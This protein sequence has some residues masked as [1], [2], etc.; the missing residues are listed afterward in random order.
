MYRGGKR[1]S[2]P[3]ASCGIGAHVVLSRP[4]SE[5]ELI[6]EPVFE[7]KVL[8]R[9]ELIGRGHMDRVRH[10]LQVLAKGDI[11]LVEGTL[12]GSPLGL[13]GRGRVGI[14]LQRRSDAAQAP[15][16]FPLPVRVRQHQVRQQAREG[17]RR[18]S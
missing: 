7:G 6:V 10:G 2:G 12:R 15:E 13:M 17:A 5:R 3:A 9:V 4:Y 18:R 8:P 14:G 16:L 1:L 11:V